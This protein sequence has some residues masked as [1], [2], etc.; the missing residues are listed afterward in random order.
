MI[1]SLVE[2]VFGYEKVYAD[3]SSWTYRKETEFLRL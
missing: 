1:L 3:G 2:G